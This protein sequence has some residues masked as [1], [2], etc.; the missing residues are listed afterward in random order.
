MTRL[1]AQFASH[2][3]PSAEVGLDLLIQED[4]STS[5]GFLQD[6]ECHGKADLLGDRDE[7]VMRLLL[8]ASLLDNVAILVSTRALLL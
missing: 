6:A 7:L 2:L 3:L 8:P 4:E 5:S 1:A